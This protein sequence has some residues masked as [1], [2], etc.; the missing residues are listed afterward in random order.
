MTSLKPATIRLPGDGLL[1]TA[2]AYGTGRWPAGIVLPWRRPEP[3]ILARCRAACRRRPGIAASPSILRGHGE[4]DWA[5]DGDYLLDAFGRDVEALIDHFDQ[6]VTLVGASRGGQC[7]LVGGSRAARPGGSLIMLAD[8]APLL[9]DDGIEDIR[10]FFRAAPPAS[11]IS[12][13]RRTT[14]ADICCT[15]RNADSSACAKSMR[16]GADGRLYWQWDPK[17]VTPEFLNP[18]SRRC[19]AGSSRATGARSSILVRAEFSSS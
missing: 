3:E 16:T 7:C 8:V 14:L 11:Q 10:A 17:T 1:L 19:L 15:G 6:K 13:K 12:T 2:D 18:P 4:S 5:A 9:R